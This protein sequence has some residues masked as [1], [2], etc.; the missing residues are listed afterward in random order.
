MANINEYLSWRGD[1]SF[2]VS[3]FNEVDNLIFS[4]LVYIDFDK[5]AADAPITLYEAARRLLAD[6]PDGVIPRGLMDAAALTELLKKAALSRRMGNVRVF[7][8]CSSIDEA[9]QKQFYA[10]TFVLG[11]GSV[12]IA[13]RGTDQTI[14]GWQEDFNM[15]FICPVPSQEEAVRYLRDVAAAYPYCDILIGG[16]SKGGN[17]AMYSA[18]FSGLHGRITRVYNNDGPGFPDKIVDCT[19]FSAITPKIISIIPQGSVVGMLL[20]H[21]EEHVIVKST[22]KGLLQHD[23]FSWE[24]RSNG[25]VELRSRNLESRLV[26]KTLT[27]WISS[28]DDNERSQFVSVLFEILSSSGAKTLA[29]LPADS[30]KI[31]KSFA[32]L[33]RE[34][35]S[36]LL[37]AVRELQNRAIHSTFAEVAH[38]LRLPQHTAE[39][40]SKN[41]CAKAYHE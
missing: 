1:I 16:H 33:D 17:L 31:L 41:A 12:Y 18:A 28:L 3:P 38:D 40:I 21:N 30:F 14:T 10:L 26:D 22:Q 6:N 23:A 29:E 20:T 37:K 25:F 39:P 7:M 5:A 13:F 15:A 36:V 8:P 11:S 35:K 24:T 4:Q 34:T 27:G 32:S 2:D 9:T 19:E